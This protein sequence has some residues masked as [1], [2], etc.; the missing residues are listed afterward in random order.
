MK[1]L[2]L[3]WGFGLALL[4]V[5]L[6]HAAGYYPLWFVDSF[7]NLIYDTRLRLTLPGTH[8]DRIAIVDI[9]EK[10]LA[11]VGRW[12]WGRDRMAELANKLLGPDGATLVG[13]DV[14]MAEPDRSS[15]LASLDMLAHGALQH[16]APY[17]A[18]LQ[19]LRGQLDYDARFATDIDGKPVVLG[20]Y[21]GT[22]AAPSGALPPPVLRA[23]NIGLADWPSYGANLPIFQQAAAD[24]GFF[25]PV[26]DFDG[27]V[28]RVPLLATYQ[29]NTYESL[30]LAMVRMLLGKPDVVPDFGAPQ[31]D[32][33]PAAGGAALEGIDLPTAMGT[34]HIPVDEH[35][36]ALVPYRGY[37]HSFRYIS[38]SDVLNDRVPRDQLQ[39]RIVLV[40]TT[41]PGLVDLRST[42]VGR[43]F[44][45][46]EIHADLIDGIL[47]GTI[48][49]APGYTNAA[50]VVTLFA[51][52]V[53]MIFFFPW[54]SPW[55]S[56]LASALL[57]AAVVAG[58]VALWQY[59][60]WALPLA[61]SIVLI[62][63]LFVW[64]MSL[65]YFIEFKTKRQ[66][67]EL[68]GQ[69]VPPEL[70]EE[71][72]RQPG[73]YS[74]AGRR[75]ELTVLFSD[76]RGFTTISEALDPEL[77]AEL[78]NDYLGTMTTVIRAHRGTLD[79]YIGD[80]IM[81]FWGAPV[82]DEFHAQSAVLAALQMQA[83]LLALNVRFA[84]R[85]WPP[86]D[87][88]IGINTGPMTVGDMGSTVRKAY[89][90]L[91][92]AVNLAARLEGVTKHYGVGIVVGEA[93]RAC[94][95]GIAY[96]ELDRVK[97]KGKLDP[98]SIFEPLG[99]ETT[100]SPRLRDEAQRWH[101][102]LAGYRSQDW[103]GAAGSIEALA[104]ERPDCRLYTLYLAR[105]AQLRVND[106]TLEWDGVYTFYTK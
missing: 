14:V 47:D 41:A 80:A 51:A 74:M 68:F 26:V 29:G 61:S 98:V 35:G 21:F 97:V 65:G 70:V 46:V 11:Q 28:R 13:F 67:A 60:D 38:A 92:D 23:S 9:D 57:L 81:T 43:A 76:I 30:S 7:D 56:T 84:D 55:R 94:T 79:K 3:R 106:S 88:G 50:Q 19:N 18:T 99:E 87:I 24:G 85:G 12:P 93:T 83:A 44:P 2:A 100:L 103:D 71:M 59:E 45:G 96:R 48:K 5:L 10:S 20:Y 31:A 77:L 22:Q 91:G 75:A 86:I 73:S 58:D 89:T 66:F 63:G 104:R 4:L 72:S 16:D 37:Q 95:P 90:V 78:M 101:E 52:G 105:I 6:G 33:A 53:L 39:G 34:I 17:L 82:A 27:S 62:L 69:Y 102:A 54:R 36:A 1:K 49:H 32:H 15:G 25:N 64:N 8:D 40:G 42:P